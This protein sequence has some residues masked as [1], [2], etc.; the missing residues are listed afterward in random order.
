MFDLGWTELAVVGIVALI[1]L[2]PKDLTVFFRNFGRFVGKAKGM[3]REF[4][5][6]MNQAADDA[7]V[8]DIQKDLNAATNP[9]KTAMDGVKD[10]TSGLEKLDLEPGSETAKLSAERA[11]AAAKIQAKSA[12]DAAERK[13]KEAADALK[14]A[15]ELEA[16]IPSATK[17][18]A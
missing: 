10:A 8:K 6:A 3:A 4:T 11:E 9:M 1:I 14:K 16:R 12:R 7:G 5:T 17:D 2:G 13:A 15:E 18:S